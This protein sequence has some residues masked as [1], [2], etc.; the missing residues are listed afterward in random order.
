MHVG[1]RGEV[2]VSGPE[3]AVLAAMALGDAVPLHRVLSAMDRSDWGGR[4]LPDMALPPDDQLAGFT[5]RVLISNLSK[6]ARRIVLG[7]AYFCVD[8]D[9]QE[10]VR[11]NQWV[12]RAADMSVTSVKRY[13][14]EVEAS[15]FVT[16][17]R[18]KNAKGLSA[19]SHYRLN[20]AAGIR[21][22]KPLAKPAKKAFTPRSFAR[23][24]SLCFS[25]P[26]KDGAAAFAEFLNSTSL[27]DPADTVLDRAGKFVW[28]NGYEVEA[29]ARAYA[30]RLDAL[31]RRYGTIEDYDL[32]GAGRA[33]AA[34]A[35]CAMI[36]GKARGQATWYLSGSNACHEIG[37][38][39]RTHGRSLIRSEDLDTWSALPEVFTV[40][41][42][43]SYGGDTKTVNGTAWSLSLD[44]A[45]KFASVSRDTK[46]YKVP[47]AVY[48]LSV[49]KRDVLYYTNSREEKEII[50]P[51]DWRGRKAHVVWRS[52]EC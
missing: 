43:T 27:T 19:A 29:A 37:S 36:D 23:T 3:H 16:V 5:A 2:E 39:I 26:K 9:T 40:Y 51:P 46:G 6:Q 22:T 21:L 48:A 10:G 52:V 38:A 44:E 7:I 50:L 30:R 18:R 47:G 28:R 17:E 49:S 32:D 33:M 11:A 13:M 25:F 12:A 8:R 31:W 24:V 41:R 14:P 34:F 35:L 20:M 45:K 42:G 1:Y 15:G 4:V